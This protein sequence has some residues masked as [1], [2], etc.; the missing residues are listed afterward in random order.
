MQNGDRHS[1][2]RR[3]QTRRRPPWRSGARNDKGL[4]LDR[5]R[6]SPLQGHRHACAGH[7]LAA[8]G[9]EEPRRVGQAPNARL[10]QLETADLFGGAVAV[11]DGAHHA[12]GRVAVA[13]ELADDVDEMLEHPGAGDRT[14]LRHVPD[15]QHRHRSGFRVGDERARDAANLG[16]AAGRPL[17]LGIGRS[18]HG[19]D[20]E[21]AGPHGVHVAQNRCEV[22]FR[23]QVETV[24]ERADALGA[25]PDL[26][27]RLFAGD[28]EHR[29]AAG[30]G[31][32][33][34][35][36]R[37]DV[38]KQSG[39]SHTRLSRE[40]DDRPGDEAASQDAVEF[41]HPRRLFDR[42]RRGDL[43]DGRRRAR[44]SEGGCAR[45]RRPDF[46]QASPRL[47]LRAAPNPFRGVPSAFGARERARRRFGCH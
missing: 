28:V 43:G 33:L 20:H 19:I 34:G 2:A 18:L 45:A 26:G 15:E 16:D 47:T 25:E 7:V 4:H 27:G 24:V 31:R 35:G 21:Q 14:F 46:L 8:R 9:Q 44:W 38:E 17:D 6:P 30:L 39:F 22:R 37:G 11:L 29:G 10:V 5:H 32:G 36:A 12:Q 3:L 1:R 23:S 41:V 40:Q 42:G 13:L